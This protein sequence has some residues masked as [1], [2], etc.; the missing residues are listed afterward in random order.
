MTMAEA[1]P[2]AAQPKVKVLRRTSE[3][4]YYQAATPHHSISFVGQSGRL[5]AVPR[6]GEFLSGKAFAYSDHLR[7]MPFA[8]LGNGP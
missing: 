1:E 7:G 5:D 3:G 6:E 8:A 2:N 4:A